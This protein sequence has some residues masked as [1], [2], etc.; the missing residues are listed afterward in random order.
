MIMGSLTATQ[1][2]ILALGLLLII[3]T[4]AVM[5][6]VWPVTAQFQHY[7]QAMERLEFNLER[8]HNIAASKA[9]L[10][11]QVEQLEDFRQ[12]QGY[13][14]VRDTPAL[15]SADLQQRV[16]RVVTEYG[17]QLR[18][19]QVVPVQLESGF[20]RIAIRMQMTGDI[21]TLRGVF[22]ELESGR[23]LLFLENVQV[24]PGRATRWRGRNRQSQETGELDINFD[25][26]AYM[27]APVS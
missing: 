12:S 25:L 24:R 23:P 11:T 5:G 26:I 14:I 19:T 16:N 4:L 13:F 1:R 21:E 15:A 22:Y 7:R 3:V 18:S 17:G 2:R 10:K 8:Y 6:L 9:P 20:S 27:R